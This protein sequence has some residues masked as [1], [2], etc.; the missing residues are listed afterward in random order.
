[1]FEDDDEDECEVPAAAFT[2]WD[3]AVAA[4]SFAH[5]VAQAV[6]RASSYFLRAVIMGN[7]YAAMQKDFEDEVRTELENLPVTVEGEDG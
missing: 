2:K 1:V 3:F 5:G 6:E 4:C 7:N